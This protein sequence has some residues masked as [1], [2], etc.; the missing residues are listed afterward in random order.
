MLDANDRSQ[1]RVMLVDEH[2]L[3]RCGLA[4]I[5]ND[6]DDMDVIAQVDSGEAALSLLESLTPDV[7]ILDVKVSGMG[8]IETTQRLKRSH[9]NVKV[10]AMSSLQVGL[11]PTRMLR[12]G[13]VAYITNC[14]SIAELMRAVRLVHSGQRYIT[15]RIANMLAMAPYGESSKS[16]FDS[17]SERELQVSLMLIDSQKVSKISD[18]LCLSPKT[19]YSYR[20]R[21]FEKLG[22]SSDVELTILAVKHG[23]S[24]AT[25]STQLN[26]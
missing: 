11:L 22:L 4:R 10:I 12:A 21:I 25:N 14:V 13:A 6:E 3:L 9:P 16:P 26:A 20:Y 17:L 8:G 23:L 7:V 19:V 1:I 2:E 15:P 24:D 5:I 18:Q